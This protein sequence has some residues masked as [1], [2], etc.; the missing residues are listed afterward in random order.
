MVAVILMVAHLKTSPVMYTMITLTK[1][2]G[3][4]TTAG[5]ELVVGS[6]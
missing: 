5:L 1:E 6:D 3:S 2:K 4:C